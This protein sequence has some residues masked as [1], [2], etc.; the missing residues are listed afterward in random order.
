MKIYEVTGIAG[1]G[2]SHIIEKIVVQ[3]ESIVLD[4]DIVNRYKLR[5]IYLIYLFF[6]IDNS[7]RLFK[8]LLKIALKLNM[9]LYDK[10]NFIR[11]S[12]KK[13]GKNYFLTYYYNENNII[14][15]DEGIS[16]IYQTIITP[17]KQDDSCILSLV[18]TLLSMLEFSHNIIV[19]DASSK[20]IY[21][22]LKSRGHNRLKSENDINFFIKKSKENL[23]VMKKQFIDTIN[24]INET[25][26]NNVPII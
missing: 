5:D 13:I 3:Q 8:I 15:V 21:N 12:I 26:E 9:K 25:K 23:L 18:D 7:F 20:T 17:S 19:V 14:I 16:H 2:K 24:I 4:V 22:R 11:N 1:V 6:K 10:I